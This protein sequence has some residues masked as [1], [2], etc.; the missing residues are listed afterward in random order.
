[1]PATISLGSTGDDVKRLQRVLARHLLWNPFG[2][3]TGVFDASLETSVKDF[4]QAN[5]L[6]V[7]GI[8]GPATWAA[9]PGYREA[10]PELKEGSE[11]PAVAWL[12]KA[13]SGMVVLVEF[14]PYSGAIDGIFGP[15]TNA[16]VRALQ[17]WAG[18]PPTGVVGD[19][20]WFIWMTPGSAQQLTLEGA[21]NLTN[22]LL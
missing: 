22:G 6:L 9:L 13:L 4:Q 1:M 14:P 17:T 2:P 19:D 12:Q 5:G 15:K 7:D 3:I 20:T 8:V 21:S 18:Q 16:A 11:G 10:S